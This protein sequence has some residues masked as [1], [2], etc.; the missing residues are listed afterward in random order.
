M[1]LSRRK[2][3]PITDNIDLAGLQDSGLTQT[4]DNLSRHHMLEGD[5]A[6]LE[7]NVILIAHPEG[8]RLGSRV[9]LSPGGYV[10]VGRAPDCHIALPEVP[11]I[12]RKHARLHHRGPTV[13]V[14]D[15]GST[16]GTY[17]NGKMI[18]Q[19]TALKSGD[20]FQAAAVHFKFLHERDVEHAYYE[21][22]YDLV[23][24]DGLTEIYNKRKYDEEVAREMARSQRYNRPLALI[25]V[26]LDSF[27]EVN[28]QQGH[29]F[30][31]VVLKEFATLVGSMLRPEQTFA[32][33]GGDE[34]V[35]LSP[36]TSLDGA[37]TLAEK[38]RSTLAVTEI[39]YADT[40]IRVT[41]SCGVAVLL[42]K[43]KI[44]EDLY[45]AADEA[46]YSSKNAGR[47][48][49]SMYGA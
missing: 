47:D 20:R 30:G 11:S 49:V 34:F 25:L 28:D 44:P 14:E 40:T 43:M 38:L 16:N 46:L 19:A 35:I 42:E 33:V 22:I 32:R 41:C 13:T 36:E 27:K 3:D 6:N 10:E 29:L 45:Q 1:T 39:H 7:A 24:R 31:D 17:V 26:D 8:Q 12:S 48:Q 4:Y 21:A 15:L 5:K 2:N 37:R 23:T 9:R 18:H